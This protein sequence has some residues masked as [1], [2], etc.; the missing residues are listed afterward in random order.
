MV[1]DTIAPSSGHRE[2]QQIDFGAVVSNGSVNRQTRQ[3]LSVIKEHKVNEKSLVFVIFHKN[4]TA[5]CF[6]LGLVT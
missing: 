6:R 3:I 4:M 5:M 2:S 1:L